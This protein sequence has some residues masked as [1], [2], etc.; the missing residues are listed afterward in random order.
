LDRYEAAR[1]AAREAL[2]DARDRT[3]ERVGE[4]E[5]A[6]FEAHE[7]F[8]DDPTIIEDV[9]AAIRE[10]T[11]AEHAVADRFDEAVAQFEDMEGRMAE[12]ADDLRDVR[13]R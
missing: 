5:A 6:V 4:E 1:D 2:R 3:A 8:L 11:P 12:R 7:G 9:E 13:D 10:G